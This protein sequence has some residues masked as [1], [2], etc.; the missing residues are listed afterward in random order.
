MMN[1]LNCVKLTVG[2]DTVQ[3]LGE[4]LP[5]VISPIKNKY[6]IMSFCAIFNNCRKI[7]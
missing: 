5:V 6:L 3:W 4:W 7:N 2:I 1:D